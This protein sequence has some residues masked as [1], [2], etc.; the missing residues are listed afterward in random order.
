MAGHGSTCSLYFLGGEGAFI[1]EFQFAHLPH[2]VF[3]CTSATSKN[4]VTAGS[5]EVLNK[6]IFCTESVLHEMSICPYSRNTA[7]RTRLGLGTGTLNVDKQ[8]LSGVRIQLTCVLQLL[9]RSDRHDADS[10]AEFSQ[11]VKI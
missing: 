1:R 11:R 10:T 3:D 9:F 4:E 5:I 8:R 7:F 2:Q 6:R